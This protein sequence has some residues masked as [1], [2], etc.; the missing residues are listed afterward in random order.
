MV[1]MPSLRNVSMLGDRAEWPP[2]S[3]S[4]QD[5]VATTPRISFKWRALWCGCQ[6][7]PS[8]SGLAREELR[9]EIPS[10]RVSRVE[11]G[12]GYRAVGTASSRRLS[13]GGG[14][15]RAEVLCDDNRLVDRAAAVRAG[16]GWWGKNSMVLIPGIGP[17]SVIGSVATDADLLPDKPLDRSCGA[18]EACL[19]ACPTGA[20][21]APGVLD[22]S[23]CLAAWAQRPGLVPPE[24]RIAMGDRL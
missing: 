24:Y 23:R 5:R 16:V 12:D 7:I 18:C 14:G 2:R 8:R 15:L 4:R 22:A 10:G 13:A 17:W 3:V 11:A 6:R 9:P 21:V 19:P 1:P 20:L